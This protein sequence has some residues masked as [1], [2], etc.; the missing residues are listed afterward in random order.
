MVGILGQRHDVLRDEETDQQTGDDLVAANVG[1]SSEM[2]LHSSRMCDC[3]WW[4]D[5]MSG[6]FL[7]VGTRKKQG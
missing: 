3:C 1:S 5:C 6:Y 4:P 7:S 2:D